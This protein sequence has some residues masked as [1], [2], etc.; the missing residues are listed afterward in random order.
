MVALPQAGER[1]GRYV[2]ERRI[3]QGGMGVVYEATD[4]QLHRAVA[5][6][7]VQP[8]LAV[9]EEFKARFEREANTLA[10]LRSRHIVQILEYGE[11]EGTVYLVT[12]FVPDGDLFGWLRTRG[13]LGPLGALKLVGPV[14]EALDDAHRAGIVHRDV[15]PSNVLLWQRTEGELI[16]Y[17]CD[18]G[19]ATDAENHQTRTGMVVG[20]LAYMSP[21][22]HLGQ[23]ATARG[24]IYSAGCLLWACLTGHPPYSGTDFQMMSAHLNQ[25]VPQLPADA[26]GAVAINPLLQ[27]AMAKDPAAR[28]PSAGAFAADITRAVDRL[29]AVARTRSAA[30]PVLPA[31]PPPTIVP[32]GPTT[33]PPGTRDISSFPPPIG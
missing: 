22:R 15:K 4:T 18:F 9:G 19:I 24:D 26:P 25:D 14:C 8:T 12:E 33:P 32:A 29:E 3:G 23:Q 31:G 21:E 27:R 17:L 7:I 20:S 16:P 2:I 11:V 30:K 28:Y 1:F 13:P 6:K 10:R 5:L